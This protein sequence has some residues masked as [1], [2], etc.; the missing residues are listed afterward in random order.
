[1]TNATYVAVPLLQIGGQNAPDNLMEDILQISVEESLHLPSMFTLV[2]YN[3]YLPGRSEDKPW[4]YDDLL[5]VGQKVK[6]GFQSSTTAAPEF[7]Q[8]H[9]DYVMDG[10]ITALESHFTSDSQAP[11]IVRGYDISH[12][13]HRGRY[14]RSFQN[15]TDSDVV[16]EIAGQLGIQIGQLDASGE[17]HDYIFQENQTNMEFLR[18]RATRIGFELFV[19]NG[20]LS[21]R[22]P[23]TSGTLQLK[24]LQDIHSFR[25]RVT[26]A[27]QVSGVEVRAW[28]YSQ[29]QAIVASKQTGQVLTETDQGSGANVSQKAGFNQDSPKLLVVDQPLFQSKQA[30]QLAQALSD[31]LAGEFVQA[32]AR[33]EGDPR[34]RPGRVVELKE[35]GKYSGRYYITETRHLYHQRRFL[36]EFSVRGLQ[37]RDILAFLSPPTHLKPGQTFMVGVVT[38]NKDPKGWGRVKVKFPTLTPQEDGSAHESNWARV[39]AVGAGAERGFDCLPEVNDEVLVGFEHGDIH[40]PY[41]LGNVWNG[42]DKP[43]V[44]VA[45]SIEQGKVR[46]RTWRTRKGHQVQFIEE[47]KNHSQQGI[48]VE[49]AKGHK[50]ICND[51]INT[52]EIHTQGGQ[53]IILDDRQGKVILQATGPVEVTANQGIKLQ[54]GGQLDLIG[55]QGIHLQTGGSVHITGNQGI[56]LQSAGSTQIIG[57]QGIQLQ[58]GGT[59]T[60]NTRILWP[61]PP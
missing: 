2:V 45:D 4:R 44:P 23:S 57:N 11:V 1:M 46:L 32:D 29:K 12:R 61:P 58:S 35:M 21:F 55:N 53:K 47:D 24:W 16:R 22:K 28:D 38:N 49:T 31:G 54:A 17:V 60:A 42:K 56:Q 48:R 59:V 6:I 33:G 19:Q 26:T 15:Y 7:A 5:R 20:Q 8:L 39:V 43:P 9:Q 34:I 41:I 40:R 51:S 10:E 37:G 52:I 3:P 18:Q 14:N 50:I 30:E 36:T 27:E 13:L 25:V